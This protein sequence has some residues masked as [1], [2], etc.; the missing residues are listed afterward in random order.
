MGI[1]LLFTSH[2][3]W[4]KNEAK[5][6]LMEH[7]TCVQRCV[8]LPSAIRVCQA[9]VL[10]CD[11]GHFEKD[12]CDISSK[13]DTHSEEVVPNTMRHHAIVSPDQGLDFNQD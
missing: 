2:D 7:S 13:V 6:E 11:L 4:Q 10:I 5:L 12:N 9:S 1:L 3:D 8:I